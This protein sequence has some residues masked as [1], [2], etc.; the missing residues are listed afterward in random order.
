MAKKVLKADQY[1]AIALIVGQD[2]NKLTTTEIAKEV[3]V[4]RSTLYEWKKDAAFTDE[5]V[6]QAE[7]MQRAFIA[8]TYAEL[9]GIIK[10]SE[11]ADNNKLKAIEIM[12][13]NQGRLK[14]VQEQTITVDDTSL[15]DL[16]AELDK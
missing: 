14:D 13:K 5:L 12:L 6:K 1:K 4:A 9:R 15:N 10:G 7:A 2:V 3:G 16:L 8:E 11:V